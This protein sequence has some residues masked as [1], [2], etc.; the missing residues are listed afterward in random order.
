MMMPHFP[1][2]EKV[3]RRKSELPFCFG[4]ECDLVPILGCGRDDSELCD[5]EDV[6]LVEERD[7]EYWSMRTSSREMEFALLRIRSSS[8]RCSWNLDCMVWVV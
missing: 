7:R 3:Q 4:N 1:F 8:S 6:V 2:F 5:A